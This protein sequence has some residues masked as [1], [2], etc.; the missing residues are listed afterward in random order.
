[1]RPVGL[2]TSS[3]VGKLPDRCSTPEAM[4]PGK[5][6]QAALHLRHE[7]GSLSSSSSSSS[8]NNASSLKDSSGYWKGERSE[9]KN[10]LVSLQMSVK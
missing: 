8:C 9:E 10:N 2:V 7:R 5:G 3:K 4:Q 6:R 1:M